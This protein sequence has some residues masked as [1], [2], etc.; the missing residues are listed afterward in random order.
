MITL[1]GFYRIAMKGLWKNSVA[2]LK[3][4]HHSQR[5]TDAGTPVLTTPFGST[6]NTWHSSSAKGLCSSPRET[7]IISALPN[8]TV[9]S[10]SEF[11]AHWAFQHNESLISI[12][13]IEPCELAFDFHQIELA[14]THF[15]NHFWG[16]VFWKEFQFILEVDGLAHAHFLQLVNDMAHHAPYLEII[17]NWNGNA[18]IVWILW[19]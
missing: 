14:V 11:N 19:L 3:S 9:K 10:V 7:T 1:P 18:W 4:R 17:I 8:W 16:P 12:G 5:L 2:N 15:S 6:S 13:V